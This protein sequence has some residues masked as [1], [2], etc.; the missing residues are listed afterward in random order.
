MSPVVRRT[1]GILIFSEFLICLG[2][3]LIFP[4][5]PF[6]K[7]SLHL[8]ATDIGVMSSLYALTQFVASPFI[9][10]WS[11]RIGRKPILVA[12]LALFAASEVLFALTNHL[13]MFD[14]SRIIGGLSAGMFVPTAQ[15]LA[16]DVTAVRQRAKVIG[17]LSASFSGGLILGPG[18]G[19]LLAGFGFKVPFWVAAGLGLC[20]LVATIGWL[21]DDRQ[22]THAT[23]VVQPDLQASD[24]RRVLGGPMTMLFVLILVS[25]FG[26]QGFES[27]YSIFV[28]EVFA[29]TLQ[30]IALVLTL[31]GIISLI[32]QVLFFDHLVAWLGEVRV[33]RYAF[34][35]SAIAVLGILFTH[36][37]PVV[38][39]ATLVAFTAFD[40]LRPAIT[41]LLTK[42]SVNNQGVINGLNMSLT[43]IGNILGPLVSSALLDWHYQVPYTVVVVFLAASYLL[44]FTVHLGT[45]KRVYTFWCWRNPTLRV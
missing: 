29:F 34:L 13:Y 22:H 2:M 9:G 30:D 10:R 36:S 16:A 42:Q 17:W 40:L 15:A 3:S 24:W 20:G 25:S 19:G 5:M 21:P 8:S 4:V 37:K 7:N 6:I 39:V 38:M 31:N 11:D 26:L 35:F 44:T 45:K 33:T 23:T 27:I 12:G 32:A 14:L 43:S 41:T 18:L 28:N 1:V